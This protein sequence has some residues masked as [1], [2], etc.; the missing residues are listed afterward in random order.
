MALPLAARGVPVSGIDLSTA[1][2]EGLRAKPGAEDV[3]VTIGDMV[4]TVVAGRFRLVY[5]RRLSPPPRQRI[6][7]RRDKHAVPVRLAL[8]AGL[9]GQAG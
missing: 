4:T 9:D 7:S 5:L 6:R 3:A 2:V 1:M 8:G